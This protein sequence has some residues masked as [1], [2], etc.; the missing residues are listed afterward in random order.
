MSKSVMHPACPP[1]Q[2]RKWSRTKGTSASLDIEKSMG[3]QT[4]YEACA[5][6]RARPEARS[7]HS[8][9]RPWLRVRGGSVRL[10]RFE[11]FEGLGFRVLL[12]IK[13]HPVVDGIEGRGHVARELRS[14]PF[15]AFP[16]PLR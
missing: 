11:S 14:L 9:F 5:R 16:R 7:Q 12:T 2:P 4:R 3:K 6:A 1:K 8:P 15:I 13:L 10:G